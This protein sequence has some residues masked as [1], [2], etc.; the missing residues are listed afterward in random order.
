MKKYERYS[1][2]DREGTTD[3]CFPISLLG[4]SEDYGYND[5]ASKKYRKGV[6]Q[7][8]GQVKYYKEGE[9]GVAVMGKIVED[10][11]TFLMA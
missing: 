8:A 6:E 5:Q 7:L 9:K 1:M 2:D 10:V 11:E 4:G 3:D